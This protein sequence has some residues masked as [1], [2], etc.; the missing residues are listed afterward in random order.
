MIE[1]K[2]KGIRFRGDEVKNERIY[3]I[4]VIG[5]P[6]VG[7]TELLTRFTSN[8]FEENYEST[9]GVSIF[10][11]SILLRKYNV[12]LN[13]MFWSIVGQPQ[14]YMLHRPYFHGADG[15]LLVFDTTRSSTFSNINNWYSSAVKYGLSGIPRILI[16]NKID[17][18]NERK[19]ILPMGEHLSAKLNAPYFETSALTGENVNVAFQRLAEL[20]YRAERS[21]ENKGGEEDQD[22]FYRVRIEEL[23]NSQ[24]GQSLCYLDEKIFVRMGFGKQFIIEIEGKKKTTGV[25]VSSKP[26]RGRGIIRLNEVQLLNAGA[27]V[28]D[29]I[30]I[31]KT[32]VFPADEIELT[33]TSVEAL[34]LKQKE[35]IK[36]KIISKPIVK[37]DI[38]EILDA[39]NQDIDPEDPVDHIMKLFSK[40]PRKKNLI[41]SIQ[42]VVENVIPSYGIVRVTRDTKVKV[43]DYIAILND[44][45]EIVSYRDIAS[46][47]DDINNYRKDVEDLLTY[48]GKLEDRIRNIE[49]EKQV[50]YLER[51]KLEYGKRILN[52]AIERLTNITDKLLNFPMLSNTR[53]ENLESVREER[54]NDELSNLKELN[55]NLTRLERLVSDNLSEESSQNTRYCNYCGGEVEDNQIFCRHCGTKIK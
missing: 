12:T 24:S 20:I 6:R 35:E 21:N 1:R 8:Q 17:L 55:R 14:F 29:F 41:R 48:T 26:D 27:K 4:I 38:V 49:N 43:N 3:K 47:I 7:K 23:D 54:E 33:P 15:M 52:N 36:A 31:K 50:L 16:G 37:G 39:E 30:M 10:K 32:R 2:S 5:D 51:Q 19:I 11:T 13:L 45:G 42:M 25:V 22:I 44:S 28:G 9:V 40:G 46:N 53:Y 18:K 34:L